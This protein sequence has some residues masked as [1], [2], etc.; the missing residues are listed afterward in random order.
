MTKNIPFPSI[1]FRKIEILN[2]RD[3]E[4]GKKGKSGKFPLEIR[5]IFLDPFPLQLL[6]QPH[7]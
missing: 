3:E 7:M 1:R 2:I 6:D 5:G 4:E